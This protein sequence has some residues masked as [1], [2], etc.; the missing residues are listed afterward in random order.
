MSLT[1]SNADDSTIDAIIPR[2]LYVGSQEARS[3]EILE[4][5][6]IQTVVSIQQHH[7]RRD[8]DEEFPDLAVL[9]EHVV[10]HPF[11]FADSSKVDI[12]DE[13]AE[14]IRLIYA[15][16]K[17]CLVHCTAG[18]SRS[19]TVVTAYLMATEGHTFAYA[20]SRVCEARPAAHINRGFREQLQAGGRWLD[21]WRNTL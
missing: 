21:A 7:E 4:R 12:G 2:R 20:Y 6:G 17:P 19:V 14:A 5:Y 15:S 10:E 16:S 9:P 18:V 1:L 8:R 11:Y 3:H 13:L